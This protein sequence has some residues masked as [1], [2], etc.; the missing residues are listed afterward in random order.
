MQL[1]FRDSAIN[2]SSTADGDLSIAADDEIDITSTLIDVNGNLDVSGTYTG[3]GLMTTGGNIVVPDAGNIGSAS[4]TDAVAISSAGVVALSATTEASATGTAALTLAGG[5][6][7]AKDMWIGDD[8]VMDSDSAVLKF[9][10]DQDVTLTHVADTGLALKSVATGDDKP[11]VF[12]LQTGETALVADE[13]VGAIRFQAPDEAG[14]GDAVL[15]C[16]GVEA[17]AEATFTDTVNK[18]SVVFK[19]GASEAAA[20]KARITSEGYLRLAGK[21]IQ[22]N[23]DTADANSLDD[24]EEG[25]ATV[26]LTAT[27]SAPSTPP[28]AT[29]TY[30][31]VGKMVTIDFIF[32]GVSMSGASG[33]VRITGLPFSAAS[34]GVAPSMQHTVGVT[35]AY[36]IWYINGTNMDLYTIA[37]DT[38]WAAEASNESSVYQYVSATYRV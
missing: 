16:A 27:T 3:G 34:I 33:G 12:T 7:V 30:V 37:D 32:N 17:V 11:I 8:I 38:G 26:T 13:V 4:D 21:G 9:G 23:A 35:G 1:Q 15:V 14:G 36:N 2:I 5:I 6:G 24:Y 19:T 25:T 31:K 18:T 28:T 20:E 22:F 10:A 29:A